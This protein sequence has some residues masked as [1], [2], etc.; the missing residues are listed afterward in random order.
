[1]KHS[2]KLIELLKT[3]SASE[4][5]AFRDF[6]ASPYFNKREE[7]V[8][9]YAHLKKAAAAGFPDKKTER[10]LKNG[11]YWKFDCQRHGDN[12][13]NGLNTKDIHID[14]QMLHVVQAQVAQDVLTL[15]RG[16]RGRRALGRFRAAP[17]T[18][19]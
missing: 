7:L 18:N 16:E 17:G 15:G 1:M 10:H 4:L 14:D 19:G 2:N 6:T 5:L 13:D 11:N 3:F 8:R 9:L 12:I